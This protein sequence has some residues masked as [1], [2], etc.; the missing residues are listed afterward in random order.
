MVP[1]GISE[2]PAEN[3]L[4]AETLKALCA[5]RHY[6]AEDARSARRFLTTL[7][8]TPPIA[9]I[10][11]EEIDKHQ[12]KAPL[13]IIESWLNMGF[14]VGLL[15][16]AGCPGVADPGADVV[17]RMHQIG[18][19][20]VP[21]VGPSSLLLALMSFGMN[22]QQFAFRGYLPR[23]SNKRKQLIKHFEKESAR[24]KIA[25]LFIE[26]PYRN[27]AL[28][29]DFIEICSPDTVIGIAVNLTGK[30]EFVKTKPCRLW[31]NHDV[32]GEDK[33]PAVFGL[34]AGF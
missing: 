19:Q 22:G 26:T 15:S 11:I 5:L 17:R 23:E 9:E 1:C 33:K 2:T 32:F 8:S 12:G 21:L 6:L 27:A 30:D 28:F 24:E 16:E 7:K 4:P 31:K 25:Q 10:A 13:D 34:W 14:D 18:I 3:V 29:K 20:V